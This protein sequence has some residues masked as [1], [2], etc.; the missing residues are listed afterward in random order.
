MASAG[1]TVEV[2]GEISELVQVGGSA[3]QFMIGS[4]AINI[5]ADTEFGDGLSALNLTNGDDLEIGGTVVNPG[6]VDALA[7][8]LHD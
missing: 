1:E 8:G 6:E 2:E 5:T 3:T 7:I 4:V